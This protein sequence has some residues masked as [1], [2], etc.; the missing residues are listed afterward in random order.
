MKVDDSLS[1]AE[2]ELLVKAHGEGTDSYA[3]RREPFV[4]LALLGL[5]RGELSGLRW[6][7]VDLGADVLT[8]GL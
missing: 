1:E 7:A 6:S 8:P 3:R 5:R 2:V 4:H